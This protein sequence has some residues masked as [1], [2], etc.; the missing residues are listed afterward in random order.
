MDIK[1]LKGVGPK[2]AEYLRSLGIYTI[3]DIFYYFPRDYE[4]RANTKKIRDLKDGEIV[5]LIAEVALING[6]RKTQTGKNLTSIVFKDD[7]GFITGIWFNQPYI[8]KTFKV[9]EKVLLYGKVNRRFAE[10][11][12]VD[13]KYEKNFDNNDENSVGI[14][15]IYP[16][17]KYLS[18]KT[19]RNI[20]KNA[21]I[22]KRELLKEIL[23]KRILDEFNLVDIQTAIDNIHFPKNKDML[24]KSIYRLKFE[25]LFLIQLGLQYYKKSINSD[26]SAYNIPLSGRLKELKEKLPF[27]LTNAQSR[28]I[29]EILL[30]MKKN[31]PMNR[32]VQGDVGSGKTVIAAIAMFNCAE[33]GYQAAMLA[34]TEILAEQHF[35][36]I[37]SLLKDFDLNIALITGSTT[38]KQ[39][40]KI[41]TDLA[42][43]EI[44]IIIGTH[45]LL[46]ENVEFKNL[47]LVVTD[48][49][50][51]FGVRQRATLV[52]KGHNPHVLVMTATPIPRTLA[53]FMYGDMDISIINELPKGRQ[54]VDTYFVRST[55][56]ERVYNFIKKEVMEGRQAYI[57]CPLV[58]ES[59]K[60]EAISAEE[61]YDF[62][63]NNT[64]NGNDKIVAVLHGKMSNEEKDFIMQKF[65]EGAIKV[66][67]STTVVEV[68]V[69]VP[70]A[71]VMVVENAERFGLAQLHQLRGRV[72]RGSLKSYCILISDATNKEAIDRLTIMTKTNDG[73]VISEKDMELRGTGELFG[74]RQHGL[75]DLKIADIFKDIEI[76]KTT[77]DLARR[78]IEDNMLEKDEFEPLRIKI[79]SMFKEKIDITTFN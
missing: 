60:I 39:K 53:L 21:L 54:K 47:A 70:N 42:N 1:Y 50:H 36:S 55:M 45:A 24:N 4:D 61:A 33:A 79:E 56:R 72:G 69:N 48:E 78:L 34:P 13:P 68:G 43:G 41:L 74:M 6:T 20:I 5:T 22:N 51:R 64:F 30:D 29:R 19:L 3:E 31:K 28:T 52:S 18:Q 14:L 77:R 66:L 37:T 32:L 73:F 59:E 38:K 2:N 17:N 10:L 35:S 57:V 25:E 49:Q 8:K 62:L 63:V 16:L 12:M 40:E 27:E 23:P 76:L 65:K 67:V 11:Q 46:Q 58:E 75:P 44:D 9:G 15:P 71:T 26:L 7:T